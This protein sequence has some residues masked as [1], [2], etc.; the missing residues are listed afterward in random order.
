MKRSKKTKDDVAERQRLGEAFAAFAVE[1]GWDEDRKLQ[2][3]A[4]LSYPD[5]WNDMVNDLV[6]V[7]ATDEAVRQLH[8][9]Y[10]GEEDYF[11]RLLTRLRQVNPTAAVKPELVDAVIAKL[12]EIKTAA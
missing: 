10:E 9:Y 8:Q 2:V 7:D 1:K 4:E 3:L 12:N 5:P 11:T 6:A